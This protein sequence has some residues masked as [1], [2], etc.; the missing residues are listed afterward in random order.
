[1]WDQGPEVSVNQIIQNLGWDL[2]SSR[3]YSARL[4]MFYKAIKS[5]VAIPIDELATRPDTRTADHNYQHIPANKINYANLFIVKLLHYSR[6]EQSSKR[7]KIN[8]K[9]WCI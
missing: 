6:V 7:N 1:M 5:D 3:G 2:V 4:I 8:F 9:C